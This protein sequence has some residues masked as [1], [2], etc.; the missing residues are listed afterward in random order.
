ML[1]QFLVYP[2]VAAQRGLVRPGMWSWMNANGNSTPASKSEAFRPPHEIEEYRLL[3]ALGRG[4]MGQVYLARDTLLDRLVAIKFVTSSRAGD[5]SYQRVL[6]E[7]RAAARV[8]HPNIVA[9][10]R[11]GELGGHPFLVSEYVRGQPLDCLSRPM[12]WPRVVEIAM[13]LGRGL[14]AAHRK[15]VLHRD[16]KPGNA[17]VAETGEVKLL[18]FGLAKLGG[19][20]HG[21]SGAATSGSDAPTL[22]RSSAVGQWQTAPVER[23][24]APPPDEEGDSTA[25]ILMAAEAAAPGG[26]APVSEHPESLTRRGAIMGTPRYMAPELWRSEPATR[27]SDLYALGAV[28]YEL[29]SGRTPYADVPRGQLRHV[30]QLRPATPLSAVAPQVPP[31][32]A[33]IVDRC[34]EIDPQRRPASAEEVCAALH[35]LRLGASEPVIPEGNP[36]RGLHAFEATHRGL[37][38]GRSS[39]ARS[40]LERLRNERLVVVAGDSGVGKSSLCRA[41]VLPLVSEGGLGEDRHWRVVTLVPGRHPL[42]ALLHALNAAPGE[43]D[44]ERGRLGYEQLARNLVRSLDGAGLVLFIDQLEELITTAKRREALAAADCLATLVARVPSLRVLG[45]VRCDFLTRLAVLP[46]LGEELA[47]GMYLLGPLSPQ[48]IREAI[49][50]P[51]RATGVAFQSEDLVDALVGATSPAEGGLPLLQ[52]ALAE[53]WEARDRE[54]GIITRAALAAVG[55]VEGALARHADRAVA[56]MLPAERTAARDILV[57]LVGDDGTR[58]RADFDELGLH[59]PA[60]RHALDALVRERLVVISEDQGRSVCTLTHDALVSHWESLRTWVSLR[61]E[62]AAVRKKLRQSAAN[63]DR[64]GRPQD[65][66]W[67]RSALVKLPR[68]VGL[69][70]REI[71]F[72]AASRRVARRTR[73]VRMAIFLAVP[74]AIAVTYVAI[75]VSDALAVRRTLDEH[76]RRA[77]PL[78]QE[79]L[80]TRERALALRREAFSLFDAGEDIRAERTWQEV[81][82]LFRELGHQHRAVAQ[83][84]EAALELDAGAPELRAL[85]AR[86]LFERAQLAEL[87]GHESEQAE[88][89]GRLS[90]YDDGAL[91]E[92]LNAPAEFLFDVRDPRATGRVHRYRC[93]EARPCRKTLVHSFSGAQLRIPLP[94]ASYLVEVSAPGRVM[95]RYPVLLR[96]GEARSIEIR[97]PLAGEV[98]AGFVYIPAGEFLSGS[99]EPYEGLRRDFLDTVPIHPRTTGAYLIDATE[100]T[101]ADWIAFLEAQPAE[102]RSRH[103]PRHS[104]GF[105]GGVKL[106]AIG[107]TWRLAFKAGDRWLE[108]EAGRQLV[109]PARVQRQR[110][111]WLRWPVSGISWEDALAYTRWLSRSGR[112]A[113]ARPCTELEWE[114]AARG[115]DSR[116][117][118]HGDLLEPDDA[119]FDL[120]YGR[121]PES[122]GPDEVGSHPA[123]DSPFGVHDMIG[124]VWELVRSARRNDQL[125]ARGGSFLQASVVQQIPNRQ[126]TLPTT[127]DNTLGF[128]V[129][130]DA[131]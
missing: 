125:V 112:L 85:M 25:V 40:V 128:R 67:P 106:T 107:D 50:G 52:F 118:P 17:I 93:V 65:A 123:S 120:T 51:A 28:L 88:L 76:R 36:Y 21:D 102:V 94:P 3:R 90:L 104:S 109:Y 2:L 81:R 58:R 32:F 53:L 19:D 55:G 114:R 108:A 6:V 75:Q 83:E 77:T 48:G 39:E 37:F 72:L 116:R 1:R 7:A 79:A 66:L 59:E 9:I 98:P 124:N 57:R 27:G 71:D 64:Q 131:P 31:A 73:M 121:D 68:F 41:G 97:L 130:A 47:R 63:W 16:V 84:L 4:G 80:A 113:G 8:Q 86:L 13:D 46:G 38:F 82:M 91:R 110:H 30:V 122:F 111:D 69:L 126:V 129:C 11:V 14:A 78:L 24:E 74:L 115:A 117:L 12:P 96:P 44:K 61:G 22:T 15:G 10:Y 45:T 42:A 49:V 35:A 56:G 101:Y 5:A 99:T 34:L 62:E 70:P 43:P 127:R 20:A 119:N 54:R 87:G 23:E 92:R 100:T 29:C 105:G 95:V 103:L 33:A 18:D 26:L 60:H 89:L